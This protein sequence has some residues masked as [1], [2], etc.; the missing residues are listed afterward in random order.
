MYQ[1]MQA[2]SLE[3]SDELYDWSPDGSEPFCLHG[4]DITMR[5]RTLKSGRHSGDCLAR[6]EPRSDTQRELRAIQHLALRE[7]SL[8]QRWKWLQTLLV[9]AF[10][11][12]V[13]TGAFLI[14]RRKQQENY[15]Q[16]V[17]NR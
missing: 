15:E 8:M 11:S 17:S 1:E 9:L 6:S 12:S 4:S 3:Y 7:T 16:A 14:L 13:A 5:N 10:A 2:A